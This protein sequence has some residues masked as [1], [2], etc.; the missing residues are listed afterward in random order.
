[1]S[2]GPV[3]GVVA[4]MAGASS[5]GVASGSVVVVAIG[6]G[7][8]GTQSGVG[9]ACCCRR[10][11]VGQVLACTTE[12]MLLFQLWHWPVHRRQLTRVA[13]WAGK[14]GSGPVLCG[15]FVDSALVL[16]VSGFTFSATGTV[17]PGA[18]L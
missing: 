3:V 12:S 11:R 4:T 6:V 5:V 13:A 8:A 9:W 16:P 10:S 17:C 18:V 2:V 15:P 1:M 7:W 14:A